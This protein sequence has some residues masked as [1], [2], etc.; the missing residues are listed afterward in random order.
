MLVEIPTYENILPL[1]SGY[2]Q[3]CAQEDIEVGPAHT[4][5][6]VSYPVTDDR[7]KLLE[8]L[9]GK[10]ADVY[11]FSCYIWNMK[12]V[13]WLLKELRDRQP[14][15]HYLLGGPQVMNHAATYLADAPANVYICNGEGERTSVE[16]FRQLNSPT[17][18]IQQVPGLSF[19]SGGELVTTEPAPRISNLME[20]P[21]PFLNG[22]FD[23]REFSMGI[24]ET[25]RGCPFRCTFCY[26]GAATNS[27]VI[28][29]EEER[30]RAEL[31][32]IADNGL[33]GLFIADAN[34]GQSPRDVEMTEHIVK[35]K[36]EVGYPLVVYMAATKNRPER[37][38]Q[39]TEIFVRGDLMVTQPI[40]LQTL[41]P[42][43]LKLI[44]RS[45]I[46]EETFVELQRTL[47]EKQI[48]SYVELIWPLPGETPESFKD[49]LT[50]LCRS[51]ADTVIVYPQLLLHNTPM[52]NQVEEYGLVTEPVPSDVSEAEV[53]VATNWVSKDECRDAYWLY[54]AMHTIYNMRGLFLL[55]G[56]LDASGIV[57]YGDLFDSVARFM[58]QRTDSEVLDLISRSLADLTNYDVLLSGKIGHMILSTHREEFDKVLVDYVT[59]QEWWSDP[60][61]R[62]AFEMDLLA[63]PY[64]YREP[65]S[66]PDY[67]FT[68]ITVHGLGDAETFLVEVSPGLAGL[69][70]EREMLHAGAR[71]DA[72]SGRVKLGVNHHARQKMPY[73]PQRS[74]EH[75][76]NYCHGT[77]LRFREILPF[78]EVHSPDT[79]ASAVAD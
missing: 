33:S 19:W 41:N 66:V 14:D 77:V 78:V 26:W 9:S 3:A 63:R 6:I 79:A 37:M 34:W 21:S 42:E 68:E 38:A 11:T 17:P 60:M 50:R 16:L 53:V 64:I 8:E 55:S 67:E 32:W 4:F 56:Y 59:T 74:L 69:L 35:R 62:Q 72:A 70:T 73:M 28:K 22:V 75:N 46:R 44:D 58:R 23:G 52:Y 51:Y 27:K 48:S 43:A 49:G 10:Y 1:A 24:L 76:A 20:I 36:K 47:R 15:A 25:N 65:V 2:I 29:F 31:D 45:N 7:H 12:L 30:I 40:S 18:D 71:S 61:A 5:E 54:H 13:S 57:S 39:I